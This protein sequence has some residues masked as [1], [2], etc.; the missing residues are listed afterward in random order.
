VGGWVGGW[1]GRWVGGCYTA[2]LGLESTN[3]L[4][5][6]RTP[7]FMLETESGMPLGAGSLHAAVGSSLALKQKY[8][9]APPNSGQKVK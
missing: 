6:G 7:A 9:L 1:V 2:Y 3:T 5:S 8:L 4:P